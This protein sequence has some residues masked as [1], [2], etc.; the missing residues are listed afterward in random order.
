MLG[1]RQLS[2]KWKCCYVLRWRSVQR[3]SLISFF[4]SLAP[5]LTEPAA[6]FAPSLTSS[7]PSFV[8]LMQLQKLRNETFNLMNRKRGKR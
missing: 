4:A 5:C 6:S 7:A 8:F 3:E 1:K 2:R